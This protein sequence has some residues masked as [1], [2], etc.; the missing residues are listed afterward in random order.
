MSHLKALIVGS[1][2]TI[3][4]AL[5]TYLQAQGWDVYGTS[6]RINNTDTQILHF[7]LT[8]E[9]TL[10]NIDQE[11]DVVYAL[12]GITN[13]DFCEKNPELSKLVNLDAQISLAKHCINKT[14]AFV[15]L[16]STAVFDGSQPLVNTNAP[17]NPK[18][19]YGKHKALFEQFLLDFSDNVTILRSSKVIA[20]KNK[21]LNDWIAALNNN[22]Q[23][24][25]FYDLS[26]CPITLIS[27]LKLLKYI[28][29][30]KSNSILH[31]SGKQDISYSELAYIIA[32]KLNKPESLIISKSY[33]DAGLTAK[34]IFKHSSLDMSETS[35]IY[36]LQP[37]SIED[38]LE[39]LLNNQHHQFII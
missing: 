37:S 39:P 23:I 15:M 27:L 24:T 21:L 30:N 4:M 20:P 35:K 12:A 38:I 34:T 8:Q 22:S 17:T 28:G 10:L 32:K 36:G 33:S 14:K 13:M 2:S 25:P 26:L 19:I 29:E 11:F 16:S 18:S 7:D 3:G 9:H 6:R 5:T 31:I 1:D